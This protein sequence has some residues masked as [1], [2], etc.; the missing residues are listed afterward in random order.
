MQA[1]MKNDRAAALNSKIALG[2]AGPV[3]WRDGAPDVSGFAPAETDYADW[4]N[5]LNDDQRLAGS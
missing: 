5:S 4:W 1:R 2:E 3:W